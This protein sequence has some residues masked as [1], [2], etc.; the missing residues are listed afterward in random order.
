M[1]EQKEAALQGREADLAGVESPLPLTLGGRWQ[2][3]AIQGQIANVLGCG[4]CRVSAAYSFAFFF[5]F[6]TLYKC[7]MILSLLVERKSLRAGF[8]LWAV[9]CQPRHHTAVFISLVKPPTT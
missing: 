6:I 5:F 7:K 4:G 8:G 1:G 3:F 9:D 2:T